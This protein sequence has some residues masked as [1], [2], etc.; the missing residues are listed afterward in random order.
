MFPITGNIGLWHI[1]FHL[2]ILKKCAFEE[3]I[4]FYGWII[5]KSILKEEYARCGLN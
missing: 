3:N 1:S 5:L 4:D 2:K